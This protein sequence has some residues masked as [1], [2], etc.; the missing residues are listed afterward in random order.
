MV[1]NVTRGHGVRKTLMPTLNQCQKRRDNN[2]LNRSAGVG[3]FWD[4]EFNPGTRLTKT[5]SSSNNNAAK[6]KATACDERN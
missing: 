2:T 4:G 6:L 1:H 5:L 3:R